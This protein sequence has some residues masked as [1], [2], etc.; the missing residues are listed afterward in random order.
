MSWSDVRYFSALLL[1]AANPMT[2]GA[3]LVVGALVSGCGAIPLA[4]L[5]VDTITG[6]AG[7]YQRYED[8]QAQKDQ[9]AEIKALREEIAAHREAVGKAASPAY[10]CAASQLDGATVFLCRPAQMDR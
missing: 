6:G 7:I 9:T 3:L 10:L 5:A 1:G 2:I 8:R 4:G